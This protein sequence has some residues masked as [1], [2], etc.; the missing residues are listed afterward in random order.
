MAFA[1]HA[2]STLSVNVPQLHASSPEG[3]SRSDFVRLCHG[4]GATCCVTYRDFLAW[5]QLSMCRRDDSLAVALTAAPCS[6]RVLS[7]R[8]TILLWIPR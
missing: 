7:V 5:S 4:D 2:R 8:V 3:P 6:E 1:F